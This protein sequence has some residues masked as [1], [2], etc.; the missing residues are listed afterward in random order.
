MSV[1]LRAV[2]VDDEPLARLRLARMLDE[3]AGVRIVG[4]YGDGPAALEG[5]RDAPAD[6]MF[7]DIR[8]PEIDGFQ[9]L[10][11]LPGLARPLVVFVSAYGERALEAFDVQAVDYLVKPLSSA[12]VHDAV[13]R[14]RARLEHLSP[15]PSPAAGD[16]TGGGRYLQR[17]AVPDGARLRM[18]AVEEITMLVAQGNYVELVLAGRSLLLR[19][20]LSS[21]VERL[22]PTRFVRIHRSRAVRIDLIEQVEPCGAG[23]YWMR[24]KDGSCLTSG[25]S[26]RKPLRDALGIA[27]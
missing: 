11:R 22:D 13:A 25:R 4:S 1:P 21:L 26:F 18:V 7:L 20:T 19:E 3:A 2:I 23:Q 5:L 14:V 16:A 6:V 15:R 24:L 9:L 27:G 8:M 12:R 17:L 10:E